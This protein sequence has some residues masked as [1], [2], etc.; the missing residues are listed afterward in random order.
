MGCRGLIKVL[1]SIGTYIRVYIYI[2]IYLFIYLYRVQATT[3]PHE[4]IEVVSDEEGSRAI[5]VYS[6]IPTY[7]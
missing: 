7:F 2:Y 5:C 6:C 3:K 4:C 1:S